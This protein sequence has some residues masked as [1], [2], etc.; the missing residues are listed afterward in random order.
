MDFYIEIKF[1]WNISKLEHLHLLVKVYDL[2]IKV[3]FIIMSQNVYFYTTCTCT[4]LFENFLFKHRWWY[5]VDICQQEID[6][7]P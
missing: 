7:F 3:I 6:C 5:P 1:K 4:V 2:R